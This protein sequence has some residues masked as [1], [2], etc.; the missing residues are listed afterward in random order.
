MKAAMAALA[1]SRTTM[2]SQVE[3]VEAVELGRHR[4][5]H[6]FGGLDRMDVAIARL[7]SGPAAQFR[8]VLA[9]HCVF[10]GVRHALL[11]VQ[12]AQAV[13]AAALLVLASR[14]APAGCG[15]CRWPV[16]QGRLGPH[17]RIGGQI[18]R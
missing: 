1:W 3:V 12:A 4:R 15:S 6:G 9:Q 17:I 16:D 18:V 8:E 7:V 11:S 14:A 10:D 13:G 5:L 2:A